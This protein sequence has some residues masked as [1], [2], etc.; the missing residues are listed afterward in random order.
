MCSPVIAV[1]GAGFSGS[2][3]ALH[4]Q[5]CCPPGTRIVLIERSGRFGPGL[6]HAIDQADNLLNVTARRM[7]AFP[8]RPT[9]FADWLQRQP[10]A[11][12]Q[13][14]VP[15][16]EAFVP[17]RLYGA[18]LTDLV[19]QGV[20]KAG[21]NRLTLRHA[22][23]MAVTKTANGMLLELQDDVPSRAGSPTQMQA[24][25]VVLATG[26]GPTLPPFDVS[27]LARA[28]L[29]RA[30][31]WDPAALAGLA[32]DASVL[33]IGSGLTMVDVAM[34]LLQAG[35]I[36]P[37][38]ALSRTGKL[39]NAH[40]DP[41]P[42]AHQLPMPLPSALVAKLRVLR[43]EAK[44]AQ[45]LGQPWH[46]VIDALRS[47]VRD[48]W[49]GLSLDDKRRFVRHLRTWWDIHHHRMAPS[50][51]THILGAVSSGQIQIRGGRVE[52]AEAVGGQARVH[53]R[54]RGDEARM[55]IDAA[56]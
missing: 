2:L 35:H 12:L 5:D 4:L 33:M 18:Y 11:V 24:D 37:M 27:A 41:A 31:P 49:Y 1:V 20:A 50:S 14:V 30:D 52:W 22:Q 26:N 13:G 36:G 47:S 39:P 42:P 45:D 19:Q 28:G 15:A 56:R 54:R 3:V 46:G 10:P 9:D 29:W 51:A 48:S 34:Q 17:R 8:D 25:V 21:R 53:Y 44:R 6:A 23:V 43:R 38:I 40:L 7:S 32:P 55:Q 16:D